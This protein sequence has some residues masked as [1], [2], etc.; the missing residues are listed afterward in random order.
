MQSPKVK[1][2]H[3]TCLIHCIPNLFVASLCI[4]P[5]LPLHFVLV[6][7]QI[8]KTSSRRSVPK[9]HSWGCP[10]LANRRTDWESGGLVTN[11]L[12]IPQIILRWLVMVSDSESAP[13]WPRFHHIILAALALPPFAFLCRLLCAFNTLLLHLMLLFLS[14]LSDSLPHAL[15]L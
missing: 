10:D 6:E 5:S 15:S 3:L 13:S 14:I 4:T 12:S 9:E 1:V 11:T 8:S 2:T 7:T